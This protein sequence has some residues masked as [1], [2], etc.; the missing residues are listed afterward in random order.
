MEVITLIGIDLGKRT[1]HLHAQDRGRHM[2][3]R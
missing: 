1:Y 3:L 2:V